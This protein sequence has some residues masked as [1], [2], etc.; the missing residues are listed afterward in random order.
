VQ[1]D[2]AHQIVEKLRLRLS[3]QQMTRMTKRQTENSEAYQLYLKGR[4]YAGKFDTENLNKGLEYLRQAIALDPNYA[5]AYDGLAYYY[6]LVLD[7][8]VPSTEA[9]PK[10][11][12]AA[13]KALEL[14]DNLV[15]AHVELAGMYYLY[16][17]D[18]AAS[19]R[20]F[21]RALELNP[22]YAPAHEYYG[23][24]LAAMGRS[25]EGISEVRRA[26]ALD[27]LSAEISSLLGWNLHSARRYDEAV[28]ELRKCV[29]LDPNYWP[30]YYYLARSY[31][32]Q[33]RFDEAIAAL[34]KARG[35][36]DQI[37]VPLGELA[38]AY[39]GSGRKA[40]ARQALAEL[41]ERS[42]RGHVSKYIIAT[43]YAALG[44]K[45]EA[46][47]RLEQ[48]YAERSWYLAFLKVDPELDS[49]RSEPRFQDLVR[50][51]NFPP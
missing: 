10:G 45:N 43:V 8:P 36:E 4:Y 16:D 20:E 31:Q 6:G 48:A 42:K 12:A 11:E 38:H 39:A 7:W 15:E 18:W 19:E 21:R 28:T 27:P 34:Q 3:N 49:L 37:A 25:D 47:N 41:L 5:L 23:W 46:L 33:G 14:D 32:Q 13:R 22:N 51:M 30:G 2:I 29:D 35:I 9:G 24:Y 17:F 44:D 50:R 40:E 26:E 1:N